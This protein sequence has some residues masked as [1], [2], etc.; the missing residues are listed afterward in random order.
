MKIYS[1]LDQLV[2]YQ[3]LTIYENEA[4]AIRDFTAFV[5]AN[6]NISD[7]AVDYSL[8]CLG[9]FDKNKGILE[10]YE[11]KVISALEIINNEI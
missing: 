4:I 1:V 9:D 5:N 11:K 8:W 3:N 2:G 7:F 6:K 10:H